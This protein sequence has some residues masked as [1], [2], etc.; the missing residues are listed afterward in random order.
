MIPRFNSVKQRSQY[1]SVIWVTL[2]G[3]FYGLLHPSDKGKHFFMDLKYG[4]IRA[5]GEFLARTLL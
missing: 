1:I 4:G 5:K 3:Y 2:E